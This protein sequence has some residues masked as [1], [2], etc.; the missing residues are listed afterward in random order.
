MRTLIQAF[1]V[2]GAIV[3]ATAAPAPAQDAAPDVGVLLDA[4]TCSEFLAL[5]AQDQM[6]VMLAMRAHMN[7]DPL[8]DEPLPIGRVGD[9]GAEGLEAG[10]EGA[11]G[12]AGA[13]EGTEA[14]GGGE[15]VEG[16]DPPD[17]T[18]IVDGE[19]ESGNVNPDGT[20]ASVSD[21]P[22]DPKLRAMRT[23]CE[24]GPESLAADAIR[25][26]HADYE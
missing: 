17:E 9:A 25:A 11:A 13:A 10:T 5:G 15:G 20:E 6:N 2:T 18:G 16:T 1:A 19:N 3:G 21:A 4:L 12:A 14:A 8:P 7:G 23:S 26:A 24:G 22:G